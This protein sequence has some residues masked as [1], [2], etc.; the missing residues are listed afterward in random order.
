[1]HYA[2]D[3]AHGMRDPE[4]YSGINFHIL[5]EGPDENGV[6]PWRK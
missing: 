2:L 6:Y 4:D 3:V 1:M 5:E